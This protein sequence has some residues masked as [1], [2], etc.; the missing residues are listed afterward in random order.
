MNFNELPWHDATLRSITI[1]REHP[2]EKDRVQLQVEWPADGELTGLV[3]VQFDDCY[4]CRTNM[5]FGIVTE[6]TILEA[7]CL[8]DSELLQQIIVKWS[9]IGV[10]L[11]KIKCYQIKTNA[12]ASLIEICASSFGIL[13]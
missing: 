3:T 9:A 11:N 1:C 6:E 5:N 7:K 13:Y 10:S 4:C 12:T 8:E 2:G